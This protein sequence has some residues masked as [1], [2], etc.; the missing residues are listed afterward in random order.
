ML[1]QLLAVADLVSQSTL[2]R[3]FGIFRHAGINQQAFVPLWN[4][5]MM[6]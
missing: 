2:S 6:S 1:R 5:A 4:W 3:F